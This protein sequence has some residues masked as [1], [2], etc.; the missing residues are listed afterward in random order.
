MTDDILKLTVKFIKK[1]KTYPTI[2]DLKD[3]GVSRDQMRSAYGNLSGLHDAA[4]EECSDFLFDINRAA[5]MNTKVL[6]QYKRFFITTA[7]TGQSVNA[8]ALKTVRTYCAKVG[9]KL[10]IIPSKNDGKLA[11][12]LDPV[13]K[14]EFIAL[15]NLD[16]NSNIK[17]L[18]IL[19]KNSKTD[20]VT[21]LPRLGKRDASYIVGGAKQ[22]LV[23]TATGLG[24]LPHATMS[25]GCITD[26]EY[27]Q[28]SLAGYAAAHDHVM[29][30]IVVEVKD[31]EI[32]HFR[33]I[34]FDSKCAMVDL[35]LF[36]SGSRTNV[37]APSAM[38]LGDWH[39][40]VT[41]PLV[42]KASIQLTE[43]LRIK[44]WIV[45]DIFDGQSI[46]HHNIGKQLLLTQKAEANKLDLTDEL[47]TLAA[48][49][50]MMSQIVKEV[51]IVKSNHDEHLAR[52]LDECRF[53]DHPYN[54]KLSIKLASAMIEGHNPVEVAVNM[55]AK[56]NRNVHWLT[57]DES[58]MVAGIECGAHGDKGANGSRGSAT[59]LENAYGKCVFGHSHTPTI[60]RDAWCVGTS[61]PPYAEYGTGPSSWMNT[62][63]LIYPNGTRQL[64]NIING[65]FTVK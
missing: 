59:S 56:P 7:G 5:P 1:N 61:T 32:Y 6:K 65:E 31:D 60:L 21:G 47:K 55:F 8:K 63:C 53:V 37:M 30:G 38:V 12:T 11:T 41:C 29:G 9:A 48:D 64:V 43:K 44:Q 15:D 40:G 4:Y 35:G 54:I 24:K 3:L 16:I 27:N 26:P 49:V 42:R 34:Q 14:D 46:S 19:Q 2:T 20:P 18:A 23:Y 36:V 10:I 58:Y 39:S 17:I 28:K 50:E 45:H 62:H 52:Y 57:R 22:R 13:L 25:T 51:V 33:Q